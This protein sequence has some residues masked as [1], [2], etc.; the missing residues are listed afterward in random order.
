MKDDLDR[1]LLSVPRAPGRKHVARLMRKRFADVI[2]THKATLASCLRSS[3]GAVSDSSIERLVGPGPVSTTSSVSGIRASGN[4]TPTPTPTPAP[5]PSDVPS[6][7]PT[8]GAGPMPAAATS[9]PPR[10]AKRGGGLAWKL[11]LVA[12]VVLIAGALAIVLPLGSDGPGEPGADAEPELTA[13]GADEV[14]QDT[15]G[16]EGAGSAGGHGPT[17]VGGDTALAERTGGTALGEGD[18]GQRDLGQRDIGEGD[19]GEGDVGEED[20]GEEDIGQGDVGQEDV[21]EEGVG[22]EEGETRAARARRLAAARA[23]RRRRRREAVQAREA[24]EEPSP[25]AETAP[26]AASEGP[27]FLTL[28]TTPWT[29]VSVGGR[30][31]GTTPLIRV[32]LPPGTHRLRLVNREQGID[33]TYPVTI[34]SGEAISRRLGLR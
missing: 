34:R 27:G 28:A 18:L 9:A 25:P 30:D 13:G 1:Y 33:E 32:E 23:L 14:P 20:I 21:G 5:A 7:T 4:A 29:H 8:P 19:V 6:V 22:G 24:S 11:G 31:L 17:D 3:E 10:E 26:T 12:I 15:A 2:E 16:E